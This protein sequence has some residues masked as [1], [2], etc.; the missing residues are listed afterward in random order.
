M[1]QR[2]QKSVYNATFMTIP[3]AAD[4]LATEA[5]APTRNQLS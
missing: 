1:W 2:A 5:R 4:G 3:D